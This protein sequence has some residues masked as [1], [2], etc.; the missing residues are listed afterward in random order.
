MNGW[1]FPMLGAEALLLAALLSVVLG[2]VN[3]FFGYRL[4]RFMLGVF[5]FL[6]GA[7]AGFFIASS[8]TDGQVLWLVLGAIVGGLA[9]AA[10]LSFLYV[11]GVFLA[12]AWAGAW[13]A[14]LAGTLTGLELPTW[15][16]I[17]AAVAVGIVALILQR[18]L[19]ILVTAFGGAW[20]V[21]QV[22][23]FLLQ[24]YGIR[25][26][27]LDVALFLL[28]VGFPAALILQW[29]HGLKGNQRVQRLEALM[30]ACWERWP[31]WGPFCSSR[32]R[33]RPGDR[34]R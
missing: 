20:A 29:Y 17:I 6:L 23:D 22:G 9:G 28:T 24:N 32:A 26:A 4:F 13:L 21:A 15:A 18:V 2:L 5:G 12:G 27:F 10:L 30:L 25:R 16:V 8:V 1:D 19:L 34:P 31:L 33:R 11:V 3:C 7:V 14:G